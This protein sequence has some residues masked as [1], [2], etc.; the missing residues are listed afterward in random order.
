M[1]TLKEEEVNGKTYGSIDEARTD[2]GTFL[3]NVYNRLHFRARLQT[4]GGVR[5]RTPP[6]RN[7]LKGLKPKPCHPNPVSQ[8]RGA[9]QPVIAVIAVIGGTS[10]PFVNH[11]GRQI[12]RWGMLGIEWLR[13]GSVLEKESSALADQAV[14]L[15]SAQ[16][17]A[18][19]VAKRLPGREP[20]SFR[21]TDASGK[22]LGVFRVKPSN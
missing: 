19:D 11:L 20:D 12:R 16:R 22:E 1:R 3:E 9:V 14:V 13:A 5:S 15:A 4:P 6:N 18:P 2:M 7:R 10:R 21:L 17:R 8:T